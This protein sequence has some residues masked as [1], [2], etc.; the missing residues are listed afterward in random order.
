MTIEEREQLYDMLDDYFNE[1][2]AGDVGGTLLSGALMSIATTAVV[3]GGGVM[4]INTAER[5]KF[6]KT[7]KLWFSMHPE[8]PSPLSSKSMNKKQALG[9]IKDNN[10]KHKCKDIDSVK[11]AGG[12]YLTKD[13]KIIAYSLWLEY[14]RDKT[15]KEIELV[16]FIAPEYKKY[17]AEYCATL[18]ILSGNC[19]DSIMAVQKRMRE[20]IIKKDP[21]KKN[22][23]E[24]HFADKGDEKEKEDE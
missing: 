11:R 16:N 7:A 9:F 4:I 8:L 24:K 10:I 17:K 12:R 5:S 3:F 1:S 14:Y 23:F 21:T 18:A 15:T 2:V 22:I 19:S 13:N 6:K 20:Y